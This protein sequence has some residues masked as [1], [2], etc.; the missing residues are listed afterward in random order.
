[1]DRLPMFGR[2]TLV[3]VVRAPW[4]HSRMNEKAPHSLVSGCSIVVMRLAPSA[5]NCRSTAPNGVIDWSLSGGNAW[6]E[7]VMRTKSSFSIHSC[8]SSCLVNLL[9]EVEPLRREAL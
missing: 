7:W 9:H 8:R 1:M 5:S 6:C 4:C 2:R 3:D